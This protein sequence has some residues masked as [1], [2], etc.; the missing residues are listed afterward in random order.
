MATQKENKVLVFEKEM[1]S[2]IVEGAD[3]SNDAVGVTYGP[4]GLNWMLEKG[5]GRPVLTRDGVTVARDIYF[6]DRA[7]NMGAGLMLEGSE[8][9]NL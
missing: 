3:A 6:S 9:T 5:F 7:K 8:K 1:R 2:K 4:R